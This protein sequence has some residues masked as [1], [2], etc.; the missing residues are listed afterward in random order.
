VSLL[1]S[2][3]SS[4]YGRVHCYSFKSIASGLRKSDFVGK[5]L[6]SPLH[7]QKFDVLWRKQQR[8][9]ARIAAAG[10]DCS[11]LDTLDD[12][13]D[14]YEDDATI[15]T[16]ATVEDVKSV[17][18]ARSLGLSNKS[19][20]ASSKSPVMMTATEMLAASSKSEANQSGFS[21]QVSSRSG[22]ELTLDSNYGFIDT[23][24]ARLLQRLACCKSCLCLQ[25]ILSFYVCSAR[26]REELL[27][28]HSKR[29]PNDF[30]SDSF[31]DT[32]FRWTK[33]DTDASRRYCKTCPLSE[34]GK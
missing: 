9:L 12:D 13:E 33:P 22:S 28:A 31:I 23:A 3:E 18:T 14:T 25:S 27:S 32:N 8:R 30:L 7:D 26:L 34:F 1:C 11:H 21:R 17:D 19:P 5:T 20:V 24:R 29:K 4:T 16:V 10:G 15:G 2:F 6:Q